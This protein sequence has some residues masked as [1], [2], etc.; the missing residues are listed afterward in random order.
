MTLQNASFEQ[1]K[2]KHRPVPNTKSPFS[3]K[4]KKWFPVH[5]SQ[6]NFFETR[7]LQ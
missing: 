2:T 4:Y 6:G 1:N 3:Q 5:F 7:L